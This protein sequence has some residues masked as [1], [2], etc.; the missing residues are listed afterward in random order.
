MA[1]L[2]QLAKLTTRGMRLE[3]G[4]G[5]TGGLKWDD[6]AAGLRGLD[7]PAYWYARAVFCQDNVFTMRL[8]DYLTMSAY[9]IIKQNGIK[10]KS[11]SN[12]H[13]AQGIATIALFGECWRRKCTHVYC[14][15]GKV[16][17]GKVCPVCE[18]RLTVEMG[19]R[20]KLSIGNLEMTPEGYNKSWLLVERELQGVFARWRA[21]ILAAMDA[22]IGEA[23]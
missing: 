12:E 2:G 10:A 4:S 8:L 17:G 14:H 6:V 7:D 9:R 20:E 13:M 5:G 22:N 19:T 3:P 1:G 21:E 16:K 18:G 23:A 11:H 15:E